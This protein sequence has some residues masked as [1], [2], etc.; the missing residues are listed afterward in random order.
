MKQNTWTQHGT[1][2]FAGNN[3]HMIAQIKQ[4]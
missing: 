4:I 3:N 1:E 2:P